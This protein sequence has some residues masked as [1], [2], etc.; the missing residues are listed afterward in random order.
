MH[1]A[2]SHMKVLEALNLTCVRGERTLFADLSF[3]LEPG[4]LLH[5]AGANGT[6]KTSL[7]RILCGLILPDEGLVRW[8]GTRIR[9]LR[10]DYWKELVYI[11]HSN[12]VKGDLTA[13]ENVQIGAQLAGHAIGSAAAL[14]AL[15][16]LGV[17]ACAS[18]PAR[19]LSQG[20]RRRVALARLFVRGASALWILDE[21]FTALDASAVMTV[22]TLLRDHSAAGGL[23]V[24]TTHQDAALDTQGQRI[25]LG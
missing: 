10:E 19:V 21:P 5:V 17:A 13:L 9:E 14:E 1:N 7:L 16:A 25:E 20:Q 18:L 2:H 12:G 6:G 4:A 23:V 11:G 8:N 22:Q 15:A 3:A 24:F